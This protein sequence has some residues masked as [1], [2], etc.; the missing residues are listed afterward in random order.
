MNNFIQI[1]YTGEKTH[2]LVADIGKQDQI[3]IRVLLERRQR[4]IQGLSV[5]TDKIN[6]M[7][8][9]SVQQ[10]MDTV[11]FTVPFIQATFP[12][13]SRPTLPGFF[14]QSMQQP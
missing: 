1:R 13:H 4:I 11:G 8:Q 12:D 10:I 9:G 6:Q 2:G 7:G 14:S 3:G 5:P